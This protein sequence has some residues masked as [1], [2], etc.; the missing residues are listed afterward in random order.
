LHDQVQGIA[1]L[2]LFGL[3]HL[4]EIH[5]VH[6]LH[7]EVVERADVAEVVNGDDAGMIQFRE[8]PGFASE[9]LRERGVAT[10]FRGQDF[11]RDDPIELRLAG[12]VNDAHAAAANQFQ[13]FE[14]GKVLGQLG[15]CRRR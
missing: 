12:L 8:R 3:D 5:P 2:D 6:K 13:D 1:W 10:R 7:D 11:Q 14:L 15:R 9:A 4:A